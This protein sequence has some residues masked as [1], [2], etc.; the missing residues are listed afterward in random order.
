LAKV[1]C[2][3]NIK[4]IHRSLIEYSR[5]TYGFQNYSRY[6]T[7]DLINCVETEVSNFF[8]KECIAPMTDGLMKFLVKSR[9]GI[10]FTPKRKFD[11]L[12]QGNDY[13][14]MGKLDQ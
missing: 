8:Y 2:H 12:H 5:I 13:V 9:V 7:I 6:N 10:Q 1:K 4:N 11:I 14:S 3:E